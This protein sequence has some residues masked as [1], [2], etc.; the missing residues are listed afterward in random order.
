MFSSTPSI[1]MRTARP[2]GSTCAA[3]I[4]DGAKL[5]LLS[6]DTA[7]THSPF[8]GIAALI[9]AGRGSVG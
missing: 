6:L 3:T 1:S 9:V 7:R 2:G 4:A 8:A 5:A